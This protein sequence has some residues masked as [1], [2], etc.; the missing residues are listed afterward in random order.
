MRVWLDKQTTLRERNKELI[1]I[2]SY[3]LESSLCKNIASSL[4]SEVRWTG[5]QEEKLTWNRGEWGQTG[6]HVNKL[7]CTRSVDTHVDLTPAP[8]LMMWLTCWINWCL[9]AYHCTH[10]TEDSEKLKEIGRTWTSSIPWIL[11]CINR[12][13]QLISDKVHGPQKPLALHGILE[14]KNG[15]RSIFTI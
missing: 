15:C 13:C 7:E 2:R 8:A 1:G 5:N 3:S 14:C 11:T 6:T 9:S 10:L 12:I 4:E